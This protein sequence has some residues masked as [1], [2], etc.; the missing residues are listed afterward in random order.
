MYRKDLFTA[1]IHVN[2]AL[3]TADLIGGVIT[4]KDPQILVRAL[5]LDDLLACIELRPCRINCDYDPGPRKPFASSMNRGLDGNA[6]FGATGFLMK[7]DNTLPPPL[8]TLTVQVL[9]CYEWHRDLQGLRPPFTPEAL[10]VRHWS[11]L[12]T[13]A[14]RNRLLL[15]NAASNTMIDLVRISLV[16]WTLL[17]PSD[18]RQI[19]TAEIIA[20]RMQYALGLEQNTDWGQNQDLRFWC[21][22]IGYFAA[23][24]PSESRTWFAKQ[25]CEIVWSAGQKIPVRT[26]GDILGDLVAFQ[27]RFL[28]REP[29]LWPHTEKLA[30]YILLK[31]ESRNGRR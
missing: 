1:K 9:E 10:T 26:D 8:K 18:M 24:D 16:T 30:R 15:L 11:T 25:I 29:A 12:R 13:L 28:F 27:K 6:Q 21:L 31:T 22:L 2:A 20:R 23:H 7:D 5:S 19:R 4:L 3:R 17:P 14:V